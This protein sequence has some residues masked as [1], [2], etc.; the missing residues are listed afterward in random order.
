MITGQ[1]RNWQPGSP[2]PAPLATL[3]KVARIMPLRGALQRWGPSDSAC[4]PEPATQQGSEYLAGYELAL[5]PE[6]QIRNV[7]T[8]QQMNAVEGGGKPGFLRHAA[9]Q[10]RGRESWSQ[11]VD[12][13]GQRGPVRAWGFRDTSSLPFVNACLALRRCSASYRLATSPAMQ[14]AG[15]LADS[16]RLRPCSLK[17]AAGCASSTVS[18][19]SC[20]LKTIPRRA[21]RWWLSIRIRCR[22]RSSAEAV[23]IAAGSCRGDML[24]DPVS[25]VFRVTGPV[26][27]PADSG[28]CSRKNHRVHLGNAFL[29]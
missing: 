10:R 25:Q 1:L 3:E 14:N 28:L 4:Q 19:R 26:T 18:I 23:G 24:Y 7:A 11:C 6:R 13:A 21:G 27:P 29:R 16:P 15:E 12:G 2:S 9:A 22:I 20:G 5:G 8:V 17:K